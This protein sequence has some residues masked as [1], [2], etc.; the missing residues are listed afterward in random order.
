[1]GGGMTQTHYILYLETNNNRTAEV[2]LFPLA[3]VSLIGLGEMCRF[4]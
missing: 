3:S 1:V 2:T 4:S